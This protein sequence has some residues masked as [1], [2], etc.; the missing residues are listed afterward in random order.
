[1]ANVRATWQILAYTPD[2]G[3]DPVGNAARGSLV[4]PVGITQTA[5]ETLLNTAGAQLIKF[6]GQ[7]VNNLPPPPC[8]DN[9]I[10][11]P[12]KLVFILANGVSVSV[13]VNVRS[14][15]LGVMSAGILAL[16]GLSTVVCV[17][18]IG[19]TW[20]NLLDIFGQSG[21][22]VTP[23]INDPRGFVYA[24]PYNYSADATNPLGGN[25]TKNF[26]VASEARNAIP[27]ILG[28]N[29]TTSAGVQLDKASVI[30]CRT[31]TRHDHR[32][33]IVTAMISRDGQIRPTKIEVPVAASV[34]ADIRT[35]GETLSTIPSVA[36][37]EYQGESYDRFHKLVP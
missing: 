27:A 21:K 2:R 6:N 19:E 35:A 32:R 26:K 33:Y 7:I 24:G 12:R 8:P 34:S 13:P 5:I 22:T 17:K 30:G 36:C 11:T 18:Y 10:F 31:G 3:A 4:V 9:K 16:Q 23:S 14:G 29:W 15:M 1:M 37:V 28:A 20:K 25:I